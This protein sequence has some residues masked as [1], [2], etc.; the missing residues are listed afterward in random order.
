[1]TSAFLKTCTY[2][3]V[4]LSPRAIADWWPRL[5]RNSGFRRLLVDQQA[6]L[7]SEDEFDKLVDDMPRGF[8]AELAHTWLKL[9]QVFS[10]TWP[11]N[12][13]E[14][15]YHDKADEAERQDSAVKSEAK[16]QG[17]DL[18]LVRD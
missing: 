8:L 9:R 15:Y 5:P 17:L 4:S 1:M 16:E 11:K 10:D 13:P 6:T 12:K 14:E 2:H 18:R 7:L 3:D